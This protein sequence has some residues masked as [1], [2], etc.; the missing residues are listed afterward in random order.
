MRKRT[1]V[2]ELLGVPASGKSGLADG[3]A[4]G[5]PGAAVIKEHQPRDL[6]ALVGGVARAGPVLLARTPDGVSRARWASWAGRLAA[7]PTVARRHATTHTQVVVLDQG[8]AYTLGRMVDV[9][10]T[11]R[12]N[13]W[14]HQQV[15]LTAALLD[16]L[17]VLE[18]EPDILSQRLHGRAKPHRAT[19][20]D[21]HDTYRYLRDEHDTCRLVAEAVAR[22]GTPVIRLDTG[23][24][25]REEQVAMVRGML[26]SATSPGGRRR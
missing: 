16:V 4:R 8:P 20:L 19:V 14:W 3:L 5:L 25:P 2:V 6:P 7:A 15:C 26:Q 12:G 11:A 17:V 23:R 22:A 9:R 24:V 10:R 13:H 1:A 18:A 21:E